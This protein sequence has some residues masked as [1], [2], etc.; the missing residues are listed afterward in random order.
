M[1]SLK[2]FGKKIW[3]GF[4]GLGKVVKIAIIVAIVTLI[5]AIVSMFFYSSANKYQLLFS[6]LEAYDAQFVTQKLTE[7][8]VD[9]KIEGDAIL[10]PKEMVDQLRL[11]IAPELTS[12]SQGYE[13]MDNMSSFGMTDE[14]FNVYK[15]RMIEGE[16]EKTIKSFSQVADAKVHITAA[17][18]SVF[19]TDAEPGK[20]AVY[21]DLKPGNKLKIEQVESIMALVSGSTDNIPTE[22]IE[23]MDSDMN[24]LSKGV[25]DEDSPYVSSDAILANIALE[26]NYEE[27]LQDTLIALLTPITG[28]DKV[29]VVVNADLDFDSK[30]KTE[31]IIDPNKVIISQQTVT[32]QN[33]N[34]SDATGGLVDDNVGSSIVDENG[35]VTS[36]RDENTTNYEVGKTENIVISAPG[37]VRRL[38]ASVIVDGNL[39][40]NVQAAIEQSVRTAIGYQ[41]ERGDA[42]SVVGINIDPTIAEDNEDMVNPFDKEAQLRNTIMYSAIAV[43]ILVGIIIAI[44][45]IFR[46]RKAKEEEESRQPLLD[47]IIDEK[48]SRVKDEPLDPINFEE[49]NPQVHLEKEIQQ[50]ASTKPDQVAEVIKSWLAESE[51]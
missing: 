2:E 8:G 19:V 33:S 5:V 26:K 45:V 36:S 6:G 49:N 13:L 20:A 39:D 16:L 40:E 7:T 51:R 23:V 43:I 34:G 31:T 25:N 47:V 4:K 10:V 32:E 14:E 29:N 41:G 37:E 21:L 27:E 17:R 38:T 11:E 3:A 28:K 30:Q 50:Y 44:V 18:D 35:N 12:G 46:K 9:M 48:I 15:N 22:N 1:N 24:L 42:V